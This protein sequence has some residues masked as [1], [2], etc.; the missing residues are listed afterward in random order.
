MAYKR[1]VVNVATSAHYRLGQDRLRSELRKL[2]EV[3][4]SWVELPLGSPQHSEIPYAFKSV[5]LKHCADQG[6]ES[7]LWCDSSIVPIRSLQPIWDRIERAGYWFSRYS[8]EVSNYEWT[9]D[10]AYDALFEKEH[11]ATPQE[12]RKLNRDIPHVVATA[13]GLNVQHPTGKEILAEYFRLATETDAFCGPWINWNH[14]DHHRRPE[15]KLPRIGVCGPS[16]VRGHRHDQT[17]LSVIAYRLGMEL[18][19]P[20]DLFAYKGFEG[21]ATVLI[22]DGGY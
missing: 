8:P 7:L 3:C 16:D 9:A 2:H 11:L 20:P 13:F 12:L 1:I 19:T 18:T 4:C 22:A 14:V 15:D 21:P 6:A 5:A 10:N 17:A